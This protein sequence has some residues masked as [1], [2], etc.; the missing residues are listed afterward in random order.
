MASKF[1]GLYEWAGAFRTIP[2]MKAEEVLGGDTV[3]YAAPSEIKKQR[4]SR[5]LIWKSRSLEYQI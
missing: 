5:I 1:G 3:R 4:N 2:I